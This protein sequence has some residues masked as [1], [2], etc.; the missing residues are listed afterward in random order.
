MIE[1]V[2]SVD[3]GTTSLKAG[4][5]TADGEVVSFSKYRFLDYDNRFIGERWML[6]LAICISKLRHQLEKKGIRDIKIL[7]IG[8][9]G[10]GPTLISKSGMTLRWNENFIVDTSATGKSIFLPRVLAFQKLF[11]REFDRTQLLFSGPEYLIYKLTGKAVTLLPENRFIPAYWDEESLD[12]IHIS[13]E[14]FPPFVAIGDNCGYLKASAI[15][16]LKLGDFLQ[17]NETIPVFSCGPD[18]TAAMVGT[19]TLRAGRIC[20]RAGSSE[21]L[22]LCIKEPVAKE[23]LRLLPSVMPGLWNISAL[24]TSSSKL[25]EKKRLVQVSDGIEALRNYARE[26]QID[27]PDEMTVTGGQTLNN[28]WMIKKAAYL[29]MKL[30]VC[31]CSDS[32]LLGDACAAWYGLGRY[33]SLQEAADNIVKQDKVYEGL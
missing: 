8:I 7:A 13:I 18:F 17:N 20:D 24:I 31:S 16:E 30:I 14:K 26:N 12:K 33:K 25:K 11:P 6:S 23:G 9:S 4:L 29:K 2:L 5:I 28:S 1:T 19:N 15:H 32:E 3:I 27:F 22:N 10:N 21:G